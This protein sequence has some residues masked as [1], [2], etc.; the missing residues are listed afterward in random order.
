MAKIP[1]G[2]EDLNCPFWQ[3]PMSEVCHKC[4]MWVQLRGKHPQSE[5]EVDDWGCSFMWLP[6]LMIETSQMERQTGAAVEGL[7]NKVSAFTSTFQRALGLS[8]KTNGSE[9]QLIEH[10]D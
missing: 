10:G 9:A 6:M 5:K 3:K 2:E 8:P 7:R 1:R 4:P